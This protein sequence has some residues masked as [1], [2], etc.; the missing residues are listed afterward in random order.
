MAELL[1]IARKEFRGFFASPAA[2]LFLG[3]FLAVTLFLFFWVEGFFAR[4]IADLRP[5]FQWMPLLLIFLVAALTMRSWSEERRSGTLESLLTSPTAPWRLVLGKFLGTM[6]LVLLALLLTLAL[7][8]TVSLLGP[9]D[10]GP[11]LGGYLASL[12]LASAY[13]AIGL[14]L[15]CRSDNPIVALILTALVCGLFYLIGSPSLTSLFGREVAQLLALIGTGSRFESITRGVVDLRDIAYYLSL[16]GVFL[17]LNLLTLERLRWAGNPNGPRQ[18]RQHLISALLVANFLVLNLW[19]APVGWLRADLTQG[20]IYSLSEATRG[21]L[22]QLQEPLLIRGYFSQQTHPLLAPLVPRIN[23]LLKEYAVAGGDKVRVELVDPQQDPQLEEEAASKYGIRPV[24]MQ[25]ASRYQAS[26]VNSYFNILVA[27]GDQYRTLGYRD[28][29]EVKGRGE[30]GLEVRLKDPEYAVTSAIR[31]V[32]NSYRAGGNPFDALTRPLVLHGYFSADDRLPEALVNLKRDLRELVKE[33]GAQAEGKL[34]LKIEDPEAGDGALARRLEQQYGF[35]PQVTSLLDTRSFWFYMLLQDGEQALQIALPETLDKASLKRAITSAVQRLSPGYLRTLTLVTPQAG[36]GPGYRRL[37]DALAENYRITRSDLRQGRVDEQ[38]DLL[39]V[40]GPEGLDEKQLFAIDQYLMRG[41]SVVMAASPYRVEVGRSIDG[42]SHESGL[43]KWLEFQGV[44][45]QKTMVLDA[46]NA[47][48]P[49][50]VQRY[51]GSLPVQEIRML[52]YPH[53]PDLRGDGLNGDSPITAG[54]GQLTLNWASPLEIDNEKQG[55]RRVTWLVRSSQRS[56][57]SDSLDL[58]PDYRSYPQDGFA[59]PDKRGREILAVAIEGRFD[60]YF[61]GKPSPLAPAGKPQP[62]DDKEKEGKGQQ[63]PRL[64]AGVI[65][66]SPQSARLILISADSFASDPVITLASQGLGSLYT[67]PIE[68]L[69]NAIDWSL[70]DQAL[71]AIRGRA[72][73]AR[74]LVPMDHETQLFW[75]YLNYVL[76]LLGLFA[77]W[78]WQ[79][80]RRKADKLRYRQILAEV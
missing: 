36:S 77:V 48:L 40:L 25:M 51:I 23:D 8:L 24:P 63:E 27:Y 43:E 54:L 31:K 46:Q 5:L 9:L 67:K 58:L 12:F 78:L 22:G 75:E 29:I 1:Q 59:A 71:L 57:R 26:V 72:A 10:W 56:W 70:E 13:V 20:R 34:Q 47:A 45:Q 55:K 28:L 64:P 73:F 18:R 14:Y 11:V 38:T 74:T 79:V 30:T 16:V 4:N 6:G 39:M 3:A 52:P 61:K 21:Y 62:G 7:P 60:S 68:F 2:Y 42:R 76:A 66:R 33:L 53:F 19:L 44:K 35:G 32:L 41:G 15:S 50:P 17:A 37:E 65:G 80:Y 69:Q 49:V